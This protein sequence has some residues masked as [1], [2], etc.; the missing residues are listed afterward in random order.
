[1]VESLNSLK[2]GSNGF[3]VKEKDVEALVEKLEFLIKNPVLRRRLGENGRKQIEQ[4][5][6]LNKLNDKLE[7]IYKDLLAENKIK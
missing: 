6:N 2:I 3:L 5:F 4:N 1:M 7:K